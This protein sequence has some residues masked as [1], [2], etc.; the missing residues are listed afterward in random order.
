V[1][2]FIYQNAGKCCADNM[3]HDIFQYYLPTFLA[4]SLT[5]NLFVQHATL[6]WYCT[7]QLSSCLSHRHPENELRNRKM[8]I[9]DLESLCNQIATPFIMYQLILNNSS[10]LIL[11]DKVSYLALRLCSRQ[12]VHNSQKS[13]R[14]RLYPLYALYYFVVSTTYV[15]IS[16]QI[17]VD[18]AKISD[19]KVTTF[20]LSYQ[21]ST[22]HLEEGHGFI[23]VEEALH[24]AAE[25]SDNDNNNFRYSDWKQDV[26]ERARRIN[27]WWRVVMNEKRCSNIFRRQLELLP[28]LRFQ[29]LQLS[30]YSL[31]LLS[32]AG[33]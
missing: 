15:H 25:A 24:A 19:A 8:H 10:C 16:R 26:R 23:G 4:S 27:D 20:H 9:T 5:N 29:V 32:F 1:S 18:A 2:F 28:Q 30:E 7:D 6:V 21:P 33:S 14:P 12:H 13:S 11:L 3:L 31:S 17:I 22:I